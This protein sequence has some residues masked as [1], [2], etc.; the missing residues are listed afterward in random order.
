MKLAPLWPSSSNI[1][2]SLPSPTSPRNTFLA[3]A[4]LVIQ[5]MSLRLDRLRWGIR[6]RGGSL[7]N[8][9]VILEPWTWNWRL[10]YESA[11]VFMSW[12]LNL[13]YWR[14]AWSNA[15]NLHRCCAG[16]LTGGCC[17]ALTHSMWNDWWGGVPLKLDCQCHRFLKHRVLE[18]WSLVFSIGNR[19]DFIYSE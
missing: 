16:L 6:T 17:N 18:F 14:H 11:V 3:K 1:L 12:S 8:F 7:Q 15:A 2:C 13:R 19:Q 4:K 10:L 5:E 9:V